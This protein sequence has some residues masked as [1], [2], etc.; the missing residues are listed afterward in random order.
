MSRFVPFTLVILHIST[1]RNY[2]VR[3]SSV[4]LRPSKGKLAG[5]YPDLE[6]HWRR[7]NLIS[8]QP[9]DLRTC[10]A[11]LERRFGSNCVSAVA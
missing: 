8:V 7:Q 5:S 6:L 2:A 10:F 4:V 9:I 3:R 11:R 1:Y